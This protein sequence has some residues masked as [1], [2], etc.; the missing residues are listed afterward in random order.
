MEGFPSSG[1]KG[2]VLGVRARGRRGCA[3]ATDVETVVSPAR[4]WRV[5]AL[6]PGLCSGTKPE[7]WNWS[8][9]KRLLGHIPQSSCA[10]PEAGMGLGC[11]CLLRVLLRRLGHGRARPSLP[12]LPSHP[13]PT[14]APVPRTKLPHSSLLQAVSGPQSSFHDVCVASVFF[15]LGGAWKHFSDHSLLKTALAFFLQ[16]LF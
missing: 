16:G 13:P 9:R 4:T 1:V 15:F 8:S 12:P 7:R 5:M 10:Q 3:A 6:C 2:P 11:Y 14:P